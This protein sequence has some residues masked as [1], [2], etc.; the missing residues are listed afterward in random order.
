MA[1][2]TSSA[3]MAQRHEPPDSLDL[4]PTP[5]WATRALI[6]HV[7]KPLGLYNATD[8]VWEPASGLGHMVRPLCEAYD[9]VAASDIFDY[10]TTPELFD[11]LSL[12]DPL[13]PAPPFDEIDWVI[14]NPPFGPAANPR[15]TRFFEI[16]NSQAKV[17][18]AMFARIQILESGNRF[19]R[20]YRRF[21]D[22]LIWAQFVER[23]NIFKGCVGAKGSKASSFGWLILD[24]TSRFNCNLPIGITSIPTVFIPPCRKA[25]ERPGDDEGP[26]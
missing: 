17:G 15:I 16:A 23:V 21:G 24:K 18:V 7:L 26:A 12:E 6:Q 8:R 10:D 13:A 3:V 22:G 11:F 4:F 1:Q 20:L 19:Q 14:T 2:N 25:L 5:L 9:Y